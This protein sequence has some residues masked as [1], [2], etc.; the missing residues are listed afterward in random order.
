VNSALAP[1]MEK[2]TARSGGYRQ[3]K[4]MSAALGRPIGPPR[5]P[6][7]E[8]DEQE[9]AEIKAILDGLGWD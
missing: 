2:T 6:T 3:G 7:I 8:C 9:L 1:W 5:P 4:A